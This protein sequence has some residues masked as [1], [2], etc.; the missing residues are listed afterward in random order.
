MEP[1]V[2]RAAAIAFAT[3]ALL[4]LPLPAAEPSTAVCPAIDTPSPTTAL[5]RLRVF[6]D[7][8]TGKRRAPTAEELR[9]IAEERLRSRAEAARVFDVIV[10]PDGMKTVDLG[11]AFLFDLVLEK[12]PDGSSRYRCAPHVA[13]PAAAAEK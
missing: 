3:A 8:A 2:F 6:I 1:A 10:Y 12:V 11:D 13:R 9:R 5:P 7:P 4:S